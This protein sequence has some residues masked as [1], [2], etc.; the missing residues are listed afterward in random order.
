MPEGWEWLDEL[1]D[2]WQ[3]PEELQGPSN[4]VPV[5]LA[6][7]IL[8]CDVLD[9][10]ARALVGRFITEDAQFTSWFLRE[11]KGSGRDIQQV[12]ALSRT[13]FRQA[14]LVFAAWQHF[15]ECLHLEGQAEDV[16][17]LL[18]AAR[19]ALDAALS[20]AVDTLVT[21]RGDRQ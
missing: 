5:N 2:E 21:A 12:A 1:A 16:A 19:E 10:E 13:P 4:G 14:R 18:A 15:R 8:S 17:P 11:V 9:L 6:I 20:T 7:Q 3:P